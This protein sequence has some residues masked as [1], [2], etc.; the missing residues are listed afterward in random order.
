MTNRTSTIGPSAEDFQHIREKIVDYLSRQSFSEKKLIQKVTDL[1][2]HYPRTKRYLF[3]TTEY[4]QQVINELKAV[5]LI[6]D[7]R[8]AEGILSQLRDRKDGIH[9]MRQKM[10]HRLI[11]KQIIEDVLREW[12]SEGMKQDY[13][14]IIRETKRKLERLR[15]KYPSKKQAY[16]IHQ[17]LFTFLG[18]K[19]YA[20]DEVRRILSEVMPRT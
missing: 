13:T 18:Q 8:Y 12:Q 9:R 1:K 5:G 20:V 2:R 16:Q 6:D 10:H 15:E 7:R 19:G 3:Y 4:V 14:A 11:P 17:K